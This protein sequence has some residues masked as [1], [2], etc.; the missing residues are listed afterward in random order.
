MCQRKDTHYSALYKIVAGYDQ[1]CGYIGCTYIFQKV[2][3]HPCVDIE[4]PPS[5]KTLNSLC[6]SYQTARRL[7]RSWCVTEMAFR[8]ALAEHWAS[9]FL[10]YLG[11]Y[12][13]SV[14]ISVECPSSHQCG[15]TWV[16]RSL[17]PRFIII[18][19]PFICFPVCIRISISFGYVLQYIFIA[20]I[21]PLSFQAA[22]PHKTR[23][24]RWGELHASV[25]TEWS[26]AC[27]HN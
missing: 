3:L 1:Q 22:I 2:I 8:V 9:T 21:A 25:V 23:Q 26:P 14:A 17:N 15:D 20:Q 13:W 27:L 4:C 12:I 11:M 7:Y 18:T 16:L 10:I 19:W 24:V 6:P 5:E